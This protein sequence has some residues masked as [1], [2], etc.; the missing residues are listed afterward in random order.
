[1]LYSIFDDEVPPSFYEN[2]PAR[3]DV[4]PTPDAADDRQARVREWLKSVTVERGFSEAE[5]AT[6]KQK[7]AEMDKAA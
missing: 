1:M 4:T 3:E 7:L 2:G 5:E 6:A